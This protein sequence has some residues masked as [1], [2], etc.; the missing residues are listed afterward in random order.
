[1][2]GRGSLTGFEQKRSVPLN[3]VLRSEG[4]GK[5]SWRLRELTALP[6]D[7]Q[8]GVYDCNSS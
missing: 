8:L 7:S 5:V 3:A 4:T 6:E 2:S 1:M